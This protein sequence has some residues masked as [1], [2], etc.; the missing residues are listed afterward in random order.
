MDLI[1]S[2]ATLQALHMS[3]DELRL[4]MAVALFQQEK[5]T[6]AQAARLAALTR[7]Q[8]QQIL[9]SR[10]IPLHYTV[11]DFESDLATIS[12]SGNQ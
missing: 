1:I 9:A 3:A 2:D 6:L 12:Q 5:F 4:E 7:W 8:F 11:D 10:K